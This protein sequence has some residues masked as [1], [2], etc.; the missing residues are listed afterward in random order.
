MAL[1]ASMLLAAV[2]LIII[3]VSPGDA[4]SPVTALAG[5]A[6]VAFVVG[7]IGLRSRM[8]KQGIG[9]LLVASAVAITATI[10]GT[11][12]RVSG[13][14]LGLPVAVVTVVVIARSRWRLGDA[15]ILALLLGL[16]TGAGYVLD[17]ALHPDTGSYGDQGTLVLVALGIALSSAAVSLLAVL[18]RGVRLLL[19]AA[20]LLA[21]ISLVGFLGALERAPTLAFGL[22]AAIVGGAGWVYVAVDLWRTKRLP[23]KASEF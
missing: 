6:L 14:A 23:R 5:L 7:L 1:V 19:A 10:V 11:T 16:G 8:T 17:A 21:A 3:V 22:G 12:V 13:V 20:C 15:G 9:P 18:P 2:A 4:S